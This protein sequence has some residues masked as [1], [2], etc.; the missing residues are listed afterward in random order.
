[1]VQRSLRFSTITT[2]GEQKWLE[3]LIHLD[4]PDATRFMR[5]ATKKD[6]I[7]ANYI[8]LGGLSLTV[9][10]DPTAYARQKGLAGNFTLMVPRRARRAY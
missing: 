8:I 3:C 7:R 2:Q 5:I 10:S 9:K 6:A 1:M 4:V